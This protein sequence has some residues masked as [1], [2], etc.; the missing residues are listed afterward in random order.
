MSFR[1]VYGRVRD[2][3]GGSVVVQESSP[4]DHVQHVWLVHEGRD[5]VDVHGTH[6]RPDPL[7]SLEQAELLARALQTFIAAHRAGPYR[8]RNGLRW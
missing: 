4:F 6:L 8:R 3:E 1:R 2:R 5:C 7:L